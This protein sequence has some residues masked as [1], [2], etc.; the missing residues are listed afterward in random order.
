MP[1]HKTRGGSVLL[2]GLAR[3]TKIFGVRKVGTAMVLGR[4]LYLAVVSLA[5]A[6]TVGCGGSDCVVGLNV[7]P[8][9]A[10]VNHSAA[11]PGNS[12]AFNSSSHFS[13]NSGCVG[14]NMAARVSSNWVAS[15]P[16]VQLSASPSPQVTATCTAA[17]ANP[18]TVTATSADG[19]ILTGKA[20]LTCN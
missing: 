9:T 5:L 10:N 7:T 15:D 12:Q 8:G 20:S 2:S 13:G 3:E 6:S 14:L 1:A 4:S 18:V 16:S 19:K 17:V 11:S